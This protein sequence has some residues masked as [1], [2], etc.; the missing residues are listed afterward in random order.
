MQV[1]QRTRR[2]GIT[3]AHCFI[4]VRS[5]LVQLL[6]LGAPAGGEH[7]S[8]SH[9]AIY[10]HGLSDARQLGAKLCELQGAG[11]QRA[12]ARPAWCQLARRV[13]HGCQPGCGAATKL[14]SQ[15]RRPPFGAGTNVWL[16]AMATANQLQ[17]GGQARRWPLRQAGGQAGIDGRASVLQHYGSSAHTQATHHPHTARCEWQARA[18]PP[19]AACVSAPVGAGQA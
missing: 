8:C 15:A 5:A 9:W 17:M 12:G 19:A 10:S 2:G 4:A 13:R 18:R 3:T 11:R 1:T 6:T 16:A 7:A 14:S